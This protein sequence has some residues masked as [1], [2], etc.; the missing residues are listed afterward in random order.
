MISTFLCNFIRDLWCK[1]LWGEGR[2]DSFMYLEINSSF[3][4][5][6]FLSFFKIIFVSFFLKIYFGYTSS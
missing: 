2:D 4:D 6:R 1:Y 3:L 5:S